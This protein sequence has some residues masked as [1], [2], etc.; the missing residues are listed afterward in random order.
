MPNFKVR[1]RSPLFADFDYAS[2]QS[3]PEYRTVHWGCHNK[4][5]SLI[6]VDARALGYAHTK[7]SR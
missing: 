3:A 7:R 6:L 4:G 1:Q 5:V 2:P